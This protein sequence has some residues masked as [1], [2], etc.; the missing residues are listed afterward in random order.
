MPLILG[1]PKD[2][3]IQLH[4]AGLPE[5]DERDW[6]TVATLYHLTNTQLGDLAPP[7]PDFGVDVLSAWSNSTTAVNYMV[8]EFFTDAPS[9]DK[10]WEDLD[11]DNR[12]ELLDSIA[13]AS[14]NPGKWYTR[15]PHWCFALIMF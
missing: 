9:L 6:K 3:R 7:V 12:K 2:L 1:Y 8:T 10:V 15:F 14:N 4:R 13:S 11:E 5:Y